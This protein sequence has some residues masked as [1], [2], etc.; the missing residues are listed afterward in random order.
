M[1]SSILYLYENPGTCSTVKTGISSISD[2]KIAARRLWTFSWVFVCVH[3]SFWVRQRFT[4]KRLKSRIYFSL[5][6]MH[7]HICI[8]TLR[9]TIQFSFKIWRL[10]ILAGIDNYSFFS[11]CASLYETDGLIF[12]S[13]KVSIPLSQ[14]K[15]A[16]GKFIP[17]L[18]YN[19]IVK[20]RILRYKRPC[21][22]KQ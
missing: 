6:I 10:G 3:M 7:L 1:S 2:M 8:H 9:F 14:A 19:S 11:I 13:K 4:E 16:I 12:C 5:Y 15:S 20:L 18:N 22:T 17:A 21:S